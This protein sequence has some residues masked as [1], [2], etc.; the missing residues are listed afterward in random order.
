MRSVG[1]GPLALLLLAVVFAGGLAGVAATQPA[2]AGGELA[3]FPAVFSGGTDGTD[4]TAP[5]ATGQLSAD[6]TASPRSGRSSPAT[7]AP[8]S[9]AGPESAAVGRDTA[10]QV[11]GESE[12]R[13]IL[14]QQFRR[15]PDE[16]GRVE[17]TYEYSIPDPVV[18]LRTALPR[19]GTVTGTDGFTDV[20]RTIFDWDGDDNDPSLTYT[21]GVNETSTGDHLAANGSLL[22][23]DVGEWS[24]F[25]R[26]GTS[27]S[28]DYQS[29]EEIRL[30]RE[31]ET[32]GPGAAGEWLVYL[33][34]HEEY[35]RS[36]DD[37]SFRLV[38]PAV[39][40]TTESPEG[41]LDAMERAANDL[42]VEEPNET[43]FTVAAPT[44][45]IPWSVRGLTIEGTDA[46]VG[47]DEA[48]DT[49]DNIWVHEFV[50]TV[51]D[52]EPT[53]ATR[54]TREGFATYY[55]AY[56]ALQHQSL[57]FEEF[58]DE[59]SIP[60]DRQAPV[61]LSEPSTWVD[62]ANY[63]R[64]ALV[65]GQI[66]RRVRQASDGE[67]T[68]GAVFAG[69]NADTDRLNASE[70]FALVDGAGDGSTD[71]AIRTAVSTDR[72]VSMWNRTQHVR[73]FGGM[74][75]RFD[76]GLPREDGEYEITGPYRNGTF[77]GTDRPTL[78]TGE[79]LVVDA[80]VRNVGGS[81]G[82]Y[83][84][85]LTVDG[86]VVD[87]ATAEV[88]AGASRAV[89]LVYTF[90]RAGQYTISVGNETETVRVLRPGAA[91]VTGL[92][93]STRTVQQYGT[94]T[95]DVTVENGLSIP[96]DRK[97]TLRRGTEDV[98]TRSVYVG[99]NATGVVEFAVDFP[100]SGNVTVATNGT[101]G[102]EVTV[103]PRERPTT[104]P[105]G[106]TD[107]ATANGA[108]N[109]GD[110]STTTSAVPGDHSIAV[111]PGYGVAVAVMI[112]LLGTLVLLARRG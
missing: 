93:V 16:P 37:Q 26:P 83:D 18:S 73:A 92:D 3:D 71:Q 5:T 78:V 54:W 72:P 80:H 2:T 24:L 87:G 90:D 4:A 103:V 109:R 84:V 76:I 62:L 14:T 68:I 107:T 1:R 30:Q 22:F 47:A 57:S 34:E 77:S 79:S 60:D 85:A 21:L 40:N 63:D 96:A 6:E 51:Q 110:A 89:P 41:V 99:P 102:V 58:R 111:G 59:L 27:T 9:Q 25:R 70:F 7:I 46:W 10:R 23:A 53:A 91:S 97:V 52:Y 106:P 98:A 105:P 100:E 42:S 64:G 108:P 104:D 69:M 48:L 19:R 28:W 15:L 66:D 75:P 94:A 38:V 56:Q 50:H 12:Q 67:R 74:P 20:N 44:E 11:D 86:S 61:T 43:V 45:S 65:A 39:A 101:D 49:T 13:I 36:T 32:V 112:G 95:V 29:P 35:T 17:V 88:P 81:S 31:T 33:G 82:Y 55:A 8:A